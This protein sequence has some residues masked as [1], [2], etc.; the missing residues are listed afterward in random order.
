MGRP[1][2][3]HLMG[4]GEITTAKPIPTNADIERLEDAM[5]AGPRLDLPLKHHFAPG[6]YVRELFVPKGTVII[7]H[8]HRNATMNIVLAGRARVLS[9]GP[10]AELAA[11]DIFTS[12]AGVRKVALVLED[13]R[14]LNVL[15]NPDNE[16]DNEKLED[17]HIIK[18]AAYQRHE[19]QTKEVKCLS[20][21]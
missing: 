17:R 7:G 9:G 21:Q 10:V 4:T 14:W 2:R 8:E 3:N 20:Q 12:G 6:V 15:P 18:S 11:G 5:L 13:L 16:T 1:Y 19:L